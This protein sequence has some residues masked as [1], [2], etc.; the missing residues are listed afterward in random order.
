LP[1]NGTHPSFPPLVV[2]RF[3]SWSCNLC[4]VGNEFNI[5]H[6]NDQRTCCRGIQET[7]TH[8]SVHARKEIDI[9][10]LIDLTGDSDDSESDHITINEEKKNDAKVS[11]DEIIGNF[12]IITCVRVF[13]LIF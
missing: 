9:N 6:Q 1:L 10:Q 12:K 4:L 13:C 5:G 11:I 8:K 3:R 2:Q 7:L